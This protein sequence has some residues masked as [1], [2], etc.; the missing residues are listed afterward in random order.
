ML[1]CLQSRCFLGLFPSGQ[2]NL[3][4]RPVGHRKDFRHRFFHT[5]HCKVP[6]LRVRQKQISVLETVPDSIML[7]GEQDEEQFLKSV[8][9]YKGYFRNKNKTTDVDVVY[10]TVE[11]NKWSEPY[12]KNEK[13]SKTQCKTELTLL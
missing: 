7:S 9:I 1:S 11:E 12:T 5:V 3:S 13:Y 10:L 2:A 8:N 6:L 4:F